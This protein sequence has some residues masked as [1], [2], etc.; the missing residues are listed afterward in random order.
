M[1]F[2][3][4]LG[5]AIGALVMLLAGAAVVYAAFTATGTGSGRAASVNAVSITVTPTM[6]A[7]A[8]LYPGG[9][10]GAICFTLTN[11]NP[12]AVH[13]TSV[14]Y[15]NSSA[16]VAINAPCPNSN[17][18]IASG[19]SSTLATPIN[20]A[21][22]TTTGTLSLPGVVQMSSAATDGCQGANFNV[23]ITLTGTQQ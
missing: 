18:S 22:N 12:Y 15:P 2:N 16:I 17:V 5:G 19:L 11:S 23:P 1:R 8:D 9:P 21:A 6:C 13:F 4:R 14:T 10:A 20:V 3:K 7:S